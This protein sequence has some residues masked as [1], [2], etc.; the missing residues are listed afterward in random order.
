MP[1]Q[2]SDSVWLNAR[3]LAPAKQAALKAVNPLI[4]IASARLKGTIVASPS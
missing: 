1:L 3:D 2:A 4:D